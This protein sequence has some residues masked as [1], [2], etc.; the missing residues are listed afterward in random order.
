MWTALLPCQRQTIKRRLFRCQ[1]LQRVV[2]AKRLSLIAMLLLGGTLNAHADNDVYDNITKHLR[3]DDVLQVDTDDCS[4]M[5]GAP[6]SGTPTS[7]SYKNCMRGRGW[8]YSHTV[9]E[10]ATRDRMNPI[11]I[12]PGRCAR[13]LRSAVSPDRTARIFEVRGRGVARRPPC[14]KTPGGWNGPGRRASQN[15]GCGEKALEHAEYDGA[16]KGDCQIR[17]HNAQFADERT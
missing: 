2:P 3:G 16:D 10:R 8:R 9:R 14:M 6:Q 15:P 11:R 1:A 17:G 12:I 5:L 4:R 13:I 7:Q